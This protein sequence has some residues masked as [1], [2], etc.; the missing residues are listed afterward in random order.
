MYKVAL[1]IVS[2]KQKKNKKELISEA[3]KMCG[4]LKDKNNCCKYN[5]IQK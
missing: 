2:G 4:F 1:N 3:S 5:R